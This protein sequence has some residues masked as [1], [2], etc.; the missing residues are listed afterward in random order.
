M[1]RRAG[2]MPALLLLAD[3]R[4]AARG[5]LQRILAPHG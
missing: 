2:Y 5:L 4:V 1:T 3:G